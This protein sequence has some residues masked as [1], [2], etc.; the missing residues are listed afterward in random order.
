MSHPTRLDPQDVFDQHRTRLDAASAAARNQTPDTR[1][2]DTAGPSPHLSVTVHGTPRASTRRAGL[3]VKVAQR[4]GLE[5]D[6][7]AAAILAALDSRLPAQ[8]ASAATPDDRLYASAWADDSGTD[9]P[10]PDALYAA[11]WGADS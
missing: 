6:A 5:G 10:A 2:A 3:R 1:P 9:E 4:L 8:S 11:A 7:P